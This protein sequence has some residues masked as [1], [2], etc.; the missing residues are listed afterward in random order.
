[1]SA[2]IFDIKRF[3]VHDGP[4]IRTTVF[5][6]GC[7]LSCWWC[8]NPES[9][10]GEIESISKTRIFE[11]QRFEQKQDSGRLLSLNQLISEVEKDRVFMEESN[12][13]ITLSGGEPLMQHDFLKDLLI[14][15]K[16]INI[17]T[18]LDTSGFTSEEIFK[19]IA[20]IPDLFLYDLKLMDD[21]A[22]KKYTGVSNKLILSNLKHLHSIRKKTWIRFPVIPGIT[23]KQDNTECMLAFLEPIKGII[24]QINLLP[25]HDI[26]KHKYLN[27]GKRN[28]LKELPGMNKEDLMPLRNIFEAAGFTVKIGG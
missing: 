1:M 6:K 28:L 20:P 25:Y 27:F 26:A 22:H 24:E 4:G 11:G 12:G 9:Q 15:S 19:E 17:H 13:G 14:K 5:F 16:E 10:N 23:D 8:H 3:A 18:A 21:E 7:P 2:I